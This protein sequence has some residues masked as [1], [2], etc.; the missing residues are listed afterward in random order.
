MKLLQDYLIV[1]M[2]KRVESVLYVPTD[3]KTE[4]TMIGSVLDASQECQG[5][6]VGS[7]V[8]FI[9]FSGFE[10][11]QNGLT[12]RIIRMKDII[13]IHG[14]EFEPAKYKFEDEKSSLLEG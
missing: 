9:P 11:T 13:L 7:V 6:S 12:C 8:R 3:V 5:I 1:R 14:D 4:T 10:H 2:M